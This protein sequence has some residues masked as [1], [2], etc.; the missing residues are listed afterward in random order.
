MGNAQNFARELAEAPANF[1][2]P[3]Q[4]VEEA[5]TGLA[6]LNIRQESTGEKKRFIFLKA[7]FRIRIGLFYQSPD[8]DK[9]R[10]LSTVKLKVLHRHWLGI[11]LLTVDVVVLWVRFRHLS[12]GFWDAA[13]VSDPYSVAFWIRIRYSDVG[14][15]NT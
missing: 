9:I 1:L 7:V 14:T 13:N 3:T 11:G 12:Q 5:T 15:K 8:R 6:G 10:I 4:F 2:T